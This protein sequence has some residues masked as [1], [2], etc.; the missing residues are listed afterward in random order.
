MTTL[1][2]DV[3]QSLLAVGWIDGDLAP[4]EA[5]AILT[6][7][8]DAGL[9]AA[10]LAALREMSAR[11]VDFSDLDMESMTREQRLYVYAVATWVAQTDETVTRDERAALHAIATLLGISGKGRRKMDELVEALR[12]RPDAPKRLDLGSL[13]AHI[14]Q[15]IREAVRPEPAPDVDDD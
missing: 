8:S 9:P 11:K 15:A 14:D 1:T 3:F 5:D 7:A 13:R 6:A 10:D 4:A 2:R 12:H